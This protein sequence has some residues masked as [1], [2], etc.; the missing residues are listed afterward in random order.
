MARASETVKAAK[1]RR[2]PKEPELPLGAHTGP[3]ILSDGGLLSWLDIP[4][5]DRRGRVV[6]DGGVLP[7]PGL[8]MIG[9][10][11]LRHRK[12]SLIDGAA[13]DAAELTT[14][15]AGYLDGVAGR[16]IRRAS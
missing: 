2:T 5:F 8:Y 10:P 16:R 15:L 6:H 11:F 12:S 13:D 9:M 14:H 7:F 1:H 4:V 3:S